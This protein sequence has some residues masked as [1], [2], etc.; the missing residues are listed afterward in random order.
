MNFCFGRVGKSGD[1]LRDR[2]TKTGIRPGHFVSIL[3]R[4]LGVN[5]G[6]IEM[7]LLT[8]TISVASTIAGTVVASL[9]YTALKQTGA[10]TAATTR[11]ATYGLGAL[12][13]AAT[14]TLLGTSSGTAAQQILVF[15]GD[16]VLASAIEV[17]S[18]KTAIV[19]S[20]AAGAAATVTSYV[21]VLVG[22]TLTD[23]AIAAIKALFQ[24]QWEVPIVFEV[25]EDADFNVI[26]S[27]TQLGVAEVCMQQWT[28]S[29]PPLSP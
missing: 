6:S 29:A 5:C 2:S 15:A 23:A 7:R 17:T 16:A 22:I 25:E 20:I 10:V 11:V 3:A 14:A 8:V 13:G 4:S 28:Q 9:V 18:E 27:Q 24:K 21:I 12:A 26:H 1:A 19:V